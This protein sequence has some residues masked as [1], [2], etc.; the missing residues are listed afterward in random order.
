M[1]ATK[2]TDEKLMREFRRRGTDDRR[3]GIPRHDCPVDGLLA[4]WWWE[5]WDGKPSEITV[6]F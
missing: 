2:E 5:G 1:V 6:A 4:K 3:D